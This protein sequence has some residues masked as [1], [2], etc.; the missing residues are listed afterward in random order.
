MQSTSVFATIANNGVRV[1]PSI[2][3]GVVDES[4]KYTPSTANE[5]TR[6]LSEQTAINMRAMMENVVSKNG[7]NR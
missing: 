4:G 1:K 3:A 5:S 2:L 7:Q 6:V